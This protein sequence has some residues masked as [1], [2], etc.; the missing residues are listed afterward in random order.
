[1]KTM[2]LKK[3][4]FSFVFVFTGISLLGQA[5]SI[6]PNIDFENGNLSGWQAFTGY[7]CP[8]ETPT[9]GLASD[10]HVLMSGNGTDPYSLGNIPVVAAGGNYSLRLGNDSTHS[11]A[12]RISYS[13][14]VSPM[15]PL[16]VYRYAVVLQYPADHPGAKQPRFEISV[17]DNRGSLLDCG[18]YKVICEN[19][20][21]EFY[22]NG[23]IRYK[24]WTDVG[25]DLTD[26]IGQ[27]ITIEFATGDCG[28]G[29]HFGYA[30]L[31]CYATTLNIS[32]NSCNPD[33][34]ITF[35]APPGFEYNWSN[36]SNTQQSTYYGLNGGD[37]ISVE[38]SAVSGCSKT[39]STIVPGFVPVAAFDYILGCDLNIDFINQSQSTGIVSHLWN[40]GD[41]A[42]AFLESPSHQFLSPGKYNV[43]LEIT[44][45]NSCKA[46]SI[47]SID[48]PEPLTAFFT[49]TPACEGEEVIFSDASSAGPGVINSWLWEWD[50]GFSPLQNPVLIFHTA[51]FHSVQLTVTTNAGCIS[52]FK[53]EV[54]VESWTEC[55]LEDNISVFIP[56]SFTPNGDDINDVFTVQSENISDFTLDIFNR[57]GERIFS[58]HDNQNGWNGNLCPGGIYTYRFSYSANHE[59]RETLMGIVALIR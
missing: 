16:F 27:S 59:K 26:Y 4:K 29:G 55:A 1:M 23:E 7:C 22:S 20:L 53:G 18:F 28:M 25:I 38:L 45:V 51:G 30:Y 14:V 31:D 17:K 5:Q 32:N 15:A 9:S 19:H 11:E 33:G 10:R 8:L 39:I 49:F 48:I 2:S 56:N 44:A 37:I 46:N 40:F 57:W 3:K 12:E 41:G 54:Q 35:T 21:P 36:G 47:K 34:S 50:N 13:F 24:K 58:T 6:Y 52:S 42:T 43:S